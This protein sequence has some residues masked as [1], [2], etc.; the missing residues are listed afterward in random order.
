MNIN[1]F[2]SREEMAERL[3]NLK[4]YIGQIDY[5]VKEGTSLAR[6]QKERDKAIMKWHAG[7]DKVIEELDLIERA[8]AD[9]DEEHYQDMLLKAKE[10]GKQKTIK[11]KRRAIIVLGM[12]IAVA[13]AILCAVLW[14]G[15]KGR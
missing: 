9:I 2:M 13:I 15:Q 4:I 6:N 8:L 5:D 11:A 12:A 1:N 10:I 14:L 3:R 7:Q